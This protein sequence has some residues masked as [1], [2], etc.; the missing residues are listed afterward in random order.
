MCVDFLTILKIF[1]IP[2][3]AYVLT[4]QDSHI[5]QMNIFFFLWGAGAFFFWL[6]HKLIKQQFSFVAY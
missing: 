5:N 6:I 1:G 3:S 4:I 2:Y